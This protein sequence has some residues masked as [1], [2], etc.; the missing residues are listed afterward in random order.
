MRININFELDD[1][2]VKECFLLNGNIDKITHNEINYST[3]NC[4]PHITLLMGEIEEKDFDKVAK[5][6]SKFSPK[7]L[8]KTLTISKPHPVFTNY[9]FSSVDEKHHSLFIED[10]KK[11]LE[12][13]EDIIQPHEYLISD[14]TSKPHITLGYVNNME[15]LDTFFQSAPVLHPCKCTKLTLSKVGIHGT[16]LND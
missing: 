15:K 13:L 11:L 8:G 6:V 12:L 1:Y 10:C 2:C 3:Q 7:C 16:A 14:G 9:I 5:I 4:H